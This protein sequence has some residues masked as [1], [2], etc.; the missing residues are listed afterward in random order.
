MIIGL[1][2]FHLGAAM[3]FLVASLACRIAKKKWAIAA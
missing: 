2:L 3:A 1:D